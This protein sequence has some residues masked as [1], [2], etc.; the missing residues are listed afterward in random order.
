MNFTFPPK[1]EYH[2][3]QKVDIKNVLDG[4]AVIGS[5]NNLPFQEELMKINETITSTEKAKRI[6]IVDPEQS[7]L[8]TAIKTYSK[9]QLI[10]IVTKKSALNG[11]ANIPIFAVRSDSIPGQAG[12]QMIHNVNIVAG[13]IPVTLLYTFL[14]DLEKNIVEL[15]RYKLGYHCSIDF[16]NAFHKNKPS[17]TTSIPL[18]EL[19]N[20]NHDKT[21]DVSNSTLICACHFT[22]KQEIGQL[23]DRCVKLIK[24]IDHDNIIYVYSLDDEKQ[25]ILK[26]H[27]ES[28]C[29]DNTY[30]IC[31]NINVSRDA[32]KYLLGINSIKSIDNVYENDGV[33]TLFN[34]SILLS[35]DLTSF[36]ADYK[37]S[38][39]KYDIVGCI[40]S[41]E[42]SW[43]IQS[44]F[45]SFKN[46]QTL[47][48]YNALLSMIDIDK[49]NIIQS[50]IDQMEVGISSFMAVKYCLGVIYPVHTISQI[51]TVGAPVEYA[52]HLRSALEYIGFPFVKKRL[53]DTL[54]NED[55]MTLLGVNLEN[56]S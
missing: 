9:A 26:Q 38:K 23:V 42:K 11:S 20:K 44:W 33:I 15:D 7:L 16:S 17:Y 50:V 56:Y 48:N 1:R 25:D 3:K 49:E 18:N 37:S 36:S 30:F 52:M 32:G 21:I 24:A 22:S 28:L 14:F 51:N 27:I 2:T 19:V 8:N 54:K 12:F 45:L 35:K 40:S 43:H 31:D 39:S 55:K 13:K 53:I 5:V 6:I 4:I 46:K 29:M 47:H 41:N 10:V 34:D